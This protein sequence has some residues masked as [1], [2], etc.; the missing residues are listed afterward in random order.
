[1]FQECISRSILIVNRNMNT[2]YKLHVTM[3]YY[4]LNPAQLIY[5]CQMISEWFLQVVYAWTKR[6]LTS[7]Y[8][9]LNSVCYYHKVI[10]P[11]FLLHKLYKAGFLRNSIELRMPLVQ[12]A[13]L[14]KVHRVLYRCVLIVLYIWNNYQEILLIFHGARWTIVYNTTC[15]CSDKWS[16]FPY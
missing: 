2:I 11:Q 9:E 14:V 7:G 8:N 13:D 10:W 1:M 15:I 3:H 4:F 16:S 6:I 12:N 5:I